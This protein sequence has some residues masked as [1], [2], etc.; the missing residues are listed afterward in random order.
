MVQVFQHEHYLRR[1]KPGMRLAVDRK[2]KDNISILNV[3]QHHA[4]AVRSA[5]VGGTD[6]RDIAEREREGGGMHAQTR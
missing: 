5:G 6:G 3:T 4:V 1:V 2:V